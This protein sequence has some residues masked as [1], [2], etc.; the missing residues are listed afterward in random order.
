MNK[1]VIPVIDVRQR[2]APTS[3]ELLETIKNID[4]SKPTLDTLGRP[5]RDLRISVTD[6]CN[7]RC[8]YCMPKSVFDRDYAYLPQKELLRFE[9][10]TTIAA[11]ATQLGVKKIRITGGEPLLRKNVEIL[12]AQLSELRTLDGKPLDLTLTTNAS[13]LKKKAQSL[14]DAGLKRL[15]ISLD[16][17]DDAIFRQMNDMDFPVADVLDGIAMASQVGF[18]D[19]KVNMVVKRGTNE[20]QILPMAAHFRG[21]GV[22]LR[23]IEY[24][25]V[26]ASNGWRMDEVLPTADVLSLLQSRWPLQA[27]P[28]KSV[29]ETATRYGYLNAQGALDPQLG[30]VGFIS[31]VTQAFCQDCNRARLSTDG[32]LFNCLFATEGANVRDLVRGAPDGDV[33]TVAQYLAYLWQQ[34]TDQYSALRQAGMVPA[35]NA[36]RRVEMSF[37]GG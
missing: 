27:L 6:R 36:E 1:P 14:K 3:Q 13:L 21:T 4:L 18:E 17:M 30:E 19:I 34:R 37:I 28:P 20:D 26:G 22:S 5:L 16:A 29:G 24:M 2:P 8:S 23:F 33:D 35:G 31:S 11:A 10:I 15:T 9:E 7:F 32:R 12:I 25:D